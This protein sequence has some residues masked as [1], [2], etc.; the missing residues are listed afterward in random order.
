MKFI[1]FIVLSIAGASLL[2][3]CEKKEGPIDPG[4]AVVNFGETSVTVSENSGLFYVPL[5]LTGEPGGYPV[6][7]N[8]TTSGV[9]DIDK[10]LLLTSTTIKITSANDSSVQM[11]PVWQPESNDSYT[12]T[13]TIESANGANIGTNNTCTINIENVMAVQYGQYNFKTSNGDPSE[14][15]LILREGANGTYIMENMFDASDS[16][17][18]VGEFDA[19][20]MQL[21]FDGRVNGFGDT[22]FNNTLGWGQRGT[23]YLAFQASLPM[24]F[25]VNENMELESTNAQFY[26]LLVK[27]NEAGTE[28]VGQETL[29][30]F[31]GGFCEYAGSESEDTWPF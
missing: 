3:S 15:T 26:F 12:V 31:N 21:S 13:L 2:F 23:D 27:M 18:L 11:I 4:T 6:T 22:N 19:E 17:K 25:T 16:P 28:V 8:I 5:E 20:K 10:V 14:W 30:S 1:K 29:A 7:V 9:D 24:V